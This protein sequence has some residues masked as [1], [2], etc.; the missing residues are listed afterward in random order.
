MRLGRGW[1]VRRGRGRSFDGLR[2]CAVVLLWVRNSCV[3]DVIAL[4]DGC[5]VLQGVGLEI[6]TRSRSKALMVCGGVQ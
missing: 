6:T 5:A 4:M 1:E 2:G 3:V